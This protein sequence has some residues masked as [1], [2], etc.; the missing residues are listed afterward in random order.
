MDCFTLVHISNP[1]LLDVYILDQWKI[2][3]GKVEE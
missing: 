2:A 3:T 1:W